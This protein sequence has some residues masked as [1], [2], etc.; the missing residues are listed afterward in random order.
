MCP[1]LKELILNFNIIRFF[2]GIHEKPI[3]SEN[4][5][6]K[7]SL[8]SLQIY[9][10]GGG[11]GLGKKRGVAFLRGV[12]TP[13]HIMKVYDYDESVFFIVLGIYISTSFD[14]GIF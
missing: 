3:E 5:F 8:D 9:R 14:V 2:E 6:K 10:G 12:D 1:H 7:G 4:F 11:G 13:M